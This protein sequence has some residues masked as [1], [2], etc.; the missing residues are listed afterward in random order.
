MYFGTFQVNSRKVSKRACWLSRFSHIGRSPR[1]WLSMWNKFIWFR[2]HR[3][4]QF[5]N[6]HH[7]PILYGSP[8]SCKGRGCCNRTFISLCKIITNYFYTYGKRGSKNQLP[9]IRPT[10]L[11]WKIRRKHIRLNFMLHCF[12]LY[13][14]L[15]SKA[16]EI[17]NYIH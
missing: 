13:L 6:A 3:L 7:L 12:Y 4:A 1:H 11:V 9:V 10:P 2:L 5:K 8:S 16:S 17:C 15:A 14:I